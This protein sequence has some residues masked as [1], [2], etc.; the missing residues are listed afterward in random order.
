MFGTFIFINWG[1]HSAESQK[2]TTIKTLASGY[3]LSLGKKSFMTVQ[4]GLA[5]KPPNPSR[6]HSNEFTRVASQWGHLLTKLS[7]C[8]FPGEANK[9]VCN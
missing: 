2:G 5:Y 7:N 4:G 3:S 8:L 1:H 9:S 6:E